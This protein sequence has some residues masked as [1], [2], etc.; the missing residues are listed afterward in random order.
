M[1]ITRLTY[2]HDFK[3]PK[4]ICSLKFDKEGFMCAVV[5]D[6]PDMNHNHWVTIVNME[7]N[8]QV[9][10][11]KHPSFP[12]TKILSLR[13]DEGLLSATQHS[14]YLWCSTTA[15]PS[16]HLF[17]RLQKNPYQVNNATLEIELT[18]CFYKNTPEFFLTI[19]QLELGFNITKQIAQSDRCFMYES[20]FYMLANCHEGFS[21]SIN[22]KTAAVVDAV[23]TS[24]DGLFLIVHTTKHQVLLVNTHDGD[25]VTSFHQISAV[26]VTLDPTKEL[27]LTMIS[28]VNSANLIGITT[29]GELV[30]INLKTDSFKKRLA[31]HELFTKKLPQK[32]KL[33]A[34]EGLSSFAVNSGNT[35]NV[36]HFD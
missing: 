8:I 4:M 12:I 3:N 32:T 5:D 35:I 16:D 27:Y 15:S 7:V 36:Y 1:A 10:K 17:P 25:L 18:D 24:T 21:N 20:F 2:R 33:V 6:V 22:F 9:A 19:D 14:V 30:V 23:N 11:F 26:Y 34:V 29:K 31:P 28:S 13:K